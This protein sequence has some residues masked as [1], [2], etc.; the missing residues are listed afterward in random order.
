[1]RSLRNIIV[2]FIAGASLLTLVSC[3][4][5]QM[6]PLQT[7]PALLQKNS[8]QEELVNP[9]A[10]NLSPAPSEESLYANDGKDV[11][12]DYLPP[13]SGVFGLGNAAQEAKI[14]SDTNEVD[15]SLD[16]SKEVCFPS[17]ESAPVVNPEVDHSKLTPSDEIVYEPLSGEYSGNPLGTLYNSDGATRIVQLPKEVEQRTISEERLLG[18][19]KI[20]YEN[21][22]KGEIEIAMDFYIR[23]KVLN[24]ELDPNVIDYGR[25]EKDYVVHFADATDDGYVSFI[26]ARDVRKTMERDYYAPYSNS[27]SSSAVGITLKKLEERIP[28]S[29]ETGSAANL[30][31]ILMPEPKFREES[32]V[33]ETRLQEVPLGGGFYDA[34]SESTF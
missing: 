33:E 15:C 2:P 22:A 16:S 6:E 32:P 23:L 12:A 8:A 1:M 24:K 9:E 13:S 10:N 21:G 20:T 14:E 26:E 3:G 27:I 18:P 17:E 28:V 30:Q 5:S 7:N 34:G 29:S 31:S 11:G 4:N 19:R 25:A